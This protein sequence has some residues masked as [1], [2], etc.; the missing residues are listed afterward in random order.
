MVFF[1]PTFFI[2][3]TLSNCVNGII[4]LNINT[5]VAAWNNKWIEKEQG[6]C[7]ALFDQLLDSLRPRAKLSDRNF[8]YSS[9][10]YRWR[11]KRFRWLSRLSDVLPHLIMGS[12]P[13]S[14]NWLHVGRVRK[15]SVEVVGFLRVLRFPPTGK[16]D[17]IGKD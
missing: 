2:S 6:V 13:V 3:Y 12:S 9:H 14:N 17:R 7:K 8:S 11:P 1:K 4:V 10:Y 15:H 5:K 16:V